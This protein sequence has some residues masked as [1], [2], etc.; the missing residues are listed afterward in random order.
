MR[1]CLRSRS[2]NPIMHRTL[3]ATVLTGFLAVTAP[4]SL[5]D[6]LWLLVSSFWNSPLE[7][8]IGCGWDP[9]GGCKPTQQSGGQ[10]EVGGALQHA[11]A[12]IG[13]GWDPNGRCNP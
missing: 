4:T 10:E 12:K 5:L 11:E 9:N 13:C 2:E 6:R 3:L 1:V 8:D 7:T